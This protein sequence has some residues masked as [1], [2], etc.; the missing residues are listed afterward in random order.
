MR[1]RTTHMPA[2]AHD[3]HEPRFESAGAPG[4][5]NESSGLALRRLPLRPSPT[6]QARMSMPPTRALQEVTDEH[7][8]RRRIRCRCRHRLG[9]SP[10]RGVLTACGPPHACSRGPGTSSRGYRAMGAGATDAPCWS[11]RRGV[12]RAESGAPSVG[13]ATVRLAGALSGPPCDADNVPRSVLAEA[14]QGRPPRRR[15]RARG[16][17]R[18]P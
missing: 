9:R 15:A 7:R 3:A 5:L 4:R 8:H 6:V 11:T 14:R 2:R 17:A 12:R 13:P 18:S 16:A 1:P 10:A